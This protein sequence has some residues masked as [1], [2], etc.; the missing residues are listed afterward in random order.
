MRP[1]TDLITATLVD[2]AI[3]LARERG[4]YGAARYLRGCGVPIDIARR[5]LTR[6]RARR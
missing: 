5:V 2:R 3:Y 6:P 1:R 4:I